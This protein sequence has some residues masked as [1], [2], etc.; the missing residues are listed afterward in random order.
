MTQFFVHQGLPL[1]ALA[2]LLESFGVPLPGETTL[3]TFAVL[4]SQGKYDIR[5]VI[6]AAASGAIVGDNLGYWLIGR[7]G[8]RALLARWRW[9]RRYAERAL[10]P[11]ETLMARHGGA[12]VFF[13]RFVAIL[14]FTVAWIAGL[15][16]MSWWRFTVWNAAG[17]IVWAAAVALVAYYLGGA[18][19]AAVERDGLYGIA[20][21][22]GAAVLGWAIVHLG[23]RRLARRLRAPLHDR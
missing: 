21:V 11:A 20:A 5:W 9:L 13:G 23:G 6:V 18:A 1:L 8:G 10:P 15:T 16:R 2:V 4:A 7:L 14:R 22:A 19:V 3:I 12:A 17:G